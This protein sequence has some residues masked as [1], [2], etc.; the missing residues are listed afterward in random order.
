MAEREA[1]HKTTVWSAG[2]FTF[3]SIYKCVRAISKA[4]TWSWQECGTGMRD[5]TS[6]IH[7]HKIAKRNRGR[8]VDYELTRNLSRR[9]C[10]KGWVV[11]RCVVNIVGECCCCCCCCCCWWWW[12]WSARWQRWT[13]CWVINFE[14]VIQTGAVECMTS[15]LTRHAVKQ[16]KWQSWITYCEEPGDE[17]DAG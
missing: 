2:S 6:T 9:P 8:K 1:V 5:S 16:S 15:W 10:I 7:G 11:K 17:L 3:W 12:W 13:D 14:G 4:V